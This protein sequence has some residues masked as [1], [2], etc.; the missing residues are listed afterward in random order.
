MKPGPGPPPVENS[1]ESVVAVPPPCVQRISVSVFNPYVSPPTG[2]T[3]VT[4]GGGTVLLMVKL[5]LVAAP[6]V[7]PGP[8]G[9]IL[10]L[11]VVVAIPPV[12][13]V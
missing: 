3:R 6:P 10:I 5:P 4:V 9:I 2:S 8:I 7:P 13:Q 12:F 1:I 11:A